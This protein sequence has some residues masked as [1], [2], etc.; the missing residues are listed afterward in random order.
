MP[1]GLPPTQGI[2]RHPGAF[3]SDTLVSKALSSR[4]R[5]RGPRLPTPAPRPAPAAPP[6]ASWPARCSGPQRP[7]RPVPPSPRHSRAAQGKPAL[8]EGRIGGAR[9]IFPSSDS[10]LPGHA[11]KRRENHSTALPTHHRPGSRTAVPA[12]QSEPVPEAG[13]LLLREPPGPAVGAAEAPIQTCPRRPPFGRLHNPS[14]WS[15]GECRPGRG[16]LPPSLHRA[17]FRNLSKGV[18]R[19]RRT[20]LR[21]LNKDPS[22]GRFSPTSHQISRSRGLTRWGQ[23]MAVFDLSSGGDSFL[24]RRPKGTLVCRTGQASPSSAATPVA[25]LPCSPQPSSSTTAPSRRL[26]TSNDASDPR[27][28]LKPLRVVTSQPKWTPSGMARLPPPACPWKRPQG[29][30]QQWRPASRGGKPAVVCSCF[31]RVRTRHSGLFHGGTRAAASSLGAS[32]SCP[33]PCAF[34]SWRG[35][36]GPFPLLQKD[37]LP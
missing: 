37:G 9:G 3:S 24:F 5:A 23:P 28:P 25:L 31:A 33:F 10:P 18:K 12:A 15:R 21:T 19:L 20:P 35:A 11:C 36:R 17:G 26:S 16:C 6:P 27:S 22:L 14:G 7:A 13:S 2:P 30:P 32:G 29:E 8:E 1:A 4:A 34:L